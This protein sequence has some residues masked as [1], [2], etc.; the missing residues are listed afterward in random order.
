MKG[1]VEYDGGDGFEIQ[2]SVSTTQL[3][4]T[5][6]SAQTVAATLTAPGVYTISGSDALTMIMPLASSVAGGMFVFRC[7]S[8][9]AHVLTGS[10]EVVG[11]KVFAGIPGAIPEGQGSKLTL[12]AVVGS[13]VSLVSDGKSFLLMAASGSCSLNG[14]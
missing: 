4:T 14:T 2:G 1:L 12:P 7:A 10:Q 11:T 5:T 6:V 9:H 13:S 8:A 3:P